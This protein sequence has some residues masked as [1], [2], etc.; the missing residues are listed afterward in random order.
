MERTDASI[1]RTILLETE[2][3]DAR[4]QWDSGYRSWPTSPEPVATPVELCS[5]LLEAAG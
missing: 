5:V 4:S 2:A 1:N 3:W